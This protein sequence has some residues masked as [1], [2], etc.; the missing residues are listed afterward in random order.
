MAWVEYYETQSVGLSHLLDNLTGVGRRAICLDMKTNKVNLTKSTKVTEREAFILDRCTAAEKC[1]AKTKADLEVAV[2]A[3]IAI[4]GW[5]Y[6]NPP[7]FHTYV[8]AFD[9]IWLRGIVAAGLYGSVQ[10]T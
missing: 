5:S 8:P 3:L 4:K 9:F 6:L 10:K 1:L 7:Q 2:R